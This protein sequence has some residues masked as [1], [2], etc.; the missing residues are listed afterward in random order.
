MGTKSTRRN[1]I[2]QLAPMIALHHVSRIDIRNGVIGFLLMTFTPFLSAA[3]NPVSVESRDMSADFEP[4]GTDGSTL[5]FQ[6]PIVDEFENQGGGET[7][8]QVQLLQQEVQELRG[9][10][11]ELTHQIGQMRRTQND[12]YLELDARFQRLTTN[13]SDPIVQQDS[14][15][16]AVPV[17]TDEDEKTQYD[18]AVELIRARQYDLAVSQ[19]EAVIAAY[20]EGTFTANAYYWLGEVHA[21]KPDPDYEAA[22]QAL[23]QVITFFPDNRKVPDAAYKLGKVYHLTGDCERATEILTQVASQ[24]QG[25]T[26]AKL[27]TDYLRDRVGSC[28]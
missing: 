25:T 26:A 3:N 4:L 16:Q 21:A 18:N 13:V 1:Q 11:E 6:P 7:Q 5:P 10:V 15:S 8:Y 23:A 22:R 27:A 24:H 12:R 28:N 14:A 19:L 9:Q 2:Q 17:V 20:P